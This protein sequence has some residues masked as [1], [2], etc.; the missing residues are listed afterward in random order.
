MARQLKIA[1]D[2]DCAKLKTD[3]ALYHDPATLQPTSYVLTIVGGGDIVNQDGNTYRMKRLEGKWKIVKGTKS[4]P[5]A[6]VF[7][8]E[9]GKPGDYFYILKGDENVLFI[10][11]ENKECRV[12]DEDFSY[13]LNRV[14]LVAGNK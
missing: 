10:L 9:L 5:D 7:Q 11:D 14:E 1:T 6:V 8:L 2:A 3:L 13:T 4:D 12:G